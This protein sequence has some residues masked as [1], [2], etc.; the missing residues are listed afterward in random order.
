MNLLAGVATA[1][2]LGK[3]QWKRTLRIGVLRVGMFGVYA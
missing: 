3:I 1:W 2:L